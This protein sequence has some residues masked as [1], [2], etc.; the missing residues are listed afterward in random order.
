[1]SASPGIGPTS[2]AP[3]PSRKAVGFGLLL[4]VFGGAWNAVVTVLCVPW[5]VHLIGIERYGLI[6]VFVTLQAVIGL[7][8]LGIGATINREMA[9]SAALGDL[10]HPRRLLRSLEL[11]YTGVAILVAAI[12]ALAAPLIATVWLKPGAI[13]RGEIEAAVR[14]MG[15]V[16]ALRWPLGLYFGALI[17]LH[18]PQ[19]SYVIT[20]AL[21]TLA[22]IGA[23]LVLGYV[24]RTIAAYF[25][26]QAGAALLALLCA[27]QAAWRAMDGAAGARFDRNLLGSVLLRSVM[28]SGV[29]ITGVVLTQVDKFAVSASVPLAV[30]GRYSLA[31]VMATGLSILVIPTFNVIYPRLSALVATDRPGEQAAFFRLGSR[32]FL[33]CLF[34]A[35]LS[36]CVHARD[37]LQIWTGNAALAAATAPVAALLCLGSTLNGVMIFPYA[38]QL[39]E[40]RTRRL[41]A[42]GCAMIAIMVPLTILLVGRHGAIGGAWS[43]V[44]LNA[45]NLALLVG[46]MRAGLPGLGPRWLLRDVLPALVVALAAVMLGQ[47]LSATV[48]PHPAARLAIAAV[49]AVP[50]TAILLLVQRDAR[51]LAIDGWHAVRA[52]L[53]RRR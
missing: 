46:A 53:E 23:V 41:L 2:P 34:P 1:M 28:M 49:C 11:V 24:E 10:D 27:R 19:A 16:I 20:T 14:L 37:L 26:W 8:D 21:A 31:G 35:A 44:A 45:I 9:R 43:W 50:A 47:A 22:S 38:L 36:A 13:G 30:F 12:V 33:A 5:F 3:A 17:G 7:L 32:L 51:A 6:G 42:I 48:G 15:I 29:A 39:A 52:G 40:G 18:R 25:L 4:G